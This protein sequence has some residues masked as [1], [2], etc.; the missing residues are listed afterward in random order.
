MKYPGRI[1]LDEKKELSFRRN[2]Y[3][4]LDVFSEK[5]LNELKFLF[6]EFVSECLPDTLYTSHNRNSFETNLE[7]S[8]AIRVLVEPEL[9]Q[10]TE[11]F[12]PIIGHF[13]SKSA[14]NDYE[15]ALHQDWNTTDELRYACA[16]IWIPL[17]DTYKKNGGIFVIPGS[18][19]F[20]TNQRSGSLSIPRVPRQDGFEELIKAV[21][22]R[23]GQAFIF[24]PA[25]FHGSY[26]NMTSNDRHVVLLSIIEKQAPFL[27]HHFDKAN[28]KVVAFVIKPE[29]IMRDLPVLEKGGLPEPL[30]VYAEYQVPALKND[31]IRLSHLKQ[32]KKL[33]WLQTIR[34]WWADYVSINR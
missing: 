13:I 10:H 2:G 19:R 31:N 20:Y 24:H 5:Q 32:K 4:I 7:I 34:Y 9:L 29:H 18:H 28:N 15:F 26:P 14:N 1:F 27:Y 33:R 12:Q 17:Q 25:L 11:V 23:A 16:S 21:P 30:E 8:R 3:L 22:V 6:K